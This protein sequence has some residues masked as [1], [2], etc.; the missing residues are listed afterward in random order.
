M[1]KRVAL[2]NSENNL[3]LETMRYKLKSEEL[4]KTLAEKV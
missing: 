2:E 1:N 4:E 3:K